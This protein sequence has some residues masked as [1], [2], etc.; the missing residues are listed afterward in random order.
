MWLIRESLRRSHPSTKCDLWEKLYNNKPPAFPKLDP[1]ELKKT[2]SHP[3]DTVPE[4]ESTVAGN[5]AILQNIIQDQCGLSRADDD[6]FFQHGLR[7]CYGDQ[8]TWARL[9]TIVKAGREHDLPGYAQMKWLCPVPALFHLRMCTLKVI[10]QQFYLP[11]KNEPQNEDDEQQDKQAPQPESSR[12]QSKKTTK[13]K[14]PPPKIWR[15]THSFLQMA[16]GFWKR[17]RISD[18]KNNEFYALEEFIIHSFDARILV[19]YWQRLLKGLKRADGSTFTL[20]DIS[21]LR[22]DELME[23]VKIAEAKLDKAGFEGILEEIHADIFM[24]MPADEEDPEYSNHLQFL[25]MVR[26]YLLLKSA[27]HFGDVGYISRAIDLL[28]IYFN[29]SRA[30]NYSMLTLWWAHHTH[31]DAA[32]DELKRAILANSL[33]N[34]TGRYGGFKEIDL[35]NEHLNK[36]IKETLRNRAGS[37]FTFSYVMRYASINSPFFHWL[38]S[39]I[40]ELFGVYSSGRHYS[41]DA[42]PDIEAYAQLLREDSFRS[43]GKDV[44]PYTYRVEDLLLLGAKHIN[45]KV[46]A[47]NAALPGE[48]LISE[49]LDELIDEELRDDFYGDKDDDNDQP[50]EQANLNEMMNGFTI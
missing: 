11:P 3:V 17:K 18:A 43:R 36:E 26:P 32:A 37:S 14:K 23:K 16:A 45:T 21:K 25:Q 10:H 31:T 46:D 40:N 12:Q 29:G 27:I 5:L 41:K 49:D 48:I 39:S 7:L 38:R 1:L 13:T 50:D 44:R 28:C 24:V 34:T 9:W 42:A 6:E 8:K 15:T 2:K 47:Y 4:D 22:V 19:A 20:N 33:V 30:K 35:F